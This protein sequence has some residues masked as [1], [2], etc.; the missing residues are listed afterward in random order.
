MKKIIFVLAAAGLMSAC[1]AGD[2]S[3]NGVDGDNTTMTAVDNT[4][5][6]D[7]GTVVTTNSSVTNTT[8]K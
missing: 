1:N 8:G 5:M 4:T 7:E 2:T 6:T 3:G